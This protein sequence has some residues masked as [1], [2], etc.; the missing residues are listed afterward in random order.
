M[1][2]TDSR[3]ARVIDDNVYFALRVV[4][5]LRD[6]VDLL[7]IGYIKHERSYVGIREALH[8]IDCPRRRVHFTCT[9]RKFLASVTAGLEISG[10]SLQGT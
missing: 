7:I 10:T 2:F 5:F 9:P 1:D 4:Y 6:R 3:G 8:R